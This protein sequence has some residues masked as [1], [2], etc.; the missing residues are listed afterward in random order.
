MGRNS[1]VT[2]RP[3]FY[4]ASLMLIIRT[5]KKLWNFRKNSVSQTDVFLASL[6]SPGCGKQAGQV[7]AKGSRL[8]ATDRGYLQETRGGP[9]RP[10]LQRT[11]GKTFLLAPGR[12]AQKSATASLFQTKHSGLNYR[13]QVKSLPWG[14]QS[15]I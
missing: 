13:L 1:A 7:D 9:G 2:A 3:V 11:L 8:W 10:L 6:K 5:R 15:E 14:I 12:G 4:S